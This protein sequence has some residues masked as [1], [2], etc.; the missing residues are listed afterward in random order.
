MR[1]PA[2]SLIFC[3]LVCLSALAWRLP[4]SSARRSLA[5]PEP[6]PTPLPCDCKGQKKITICHAPP[7]NPENAHT[8]EISCNG[9]NGHQHHPQDYCGPCREHPPAPPEGSC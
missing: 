2:A 8:I 5:T 3:L 7:G 9:Q 6:T 1:K 4:A